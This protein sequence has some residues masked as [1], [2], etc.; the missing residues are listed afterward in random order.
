MPAD[1]H[2]E[3]RSNPE[4]MNINVLQNTPLVETK[5]S[6]KILKD[7]IFIATGLYLF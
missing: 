7:K 3:E 4:M 1:R 5:Q 2:C 6:G